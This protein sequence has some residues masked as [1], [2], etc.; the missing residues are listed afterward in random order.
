MAKIRKSKLKKMFVLA[1]LSRTK[2][3]EALRTMG[4]THIKGKVL[5]EQWSEKNPTRNYCYVVS[6]FLFWYVAPDGSV[7]YSVAVE[8]DDAVHVFMRWPDET[9]VD[10]TC[11]Q[12]SDMDDIHYKAEKRKTFMQSGG[13]GPSKRARI[14]AE[15][16]GFKDKDILEK[17]KFRHKGSKKPIDAPITKGKK[18]TKVKKLNKEGAPPKNQSKRL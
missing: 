8:G 6:E 7:A 4:T 12:F 15:L 17:M 3:K 2:L 16:M 5:K 13:A 1:G 18:A 14:L 9:L 10:L 11:D